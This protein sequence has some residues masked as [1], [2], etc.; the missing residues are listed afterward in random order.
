M[1]LPPFFPTPRCFGLLFPWRIRIRIQRTDPEDPGNWVQAF[2]VSLGQGPNLNL[3][4]G[5]PGPREAAGPMASV[6]SY[7]QPQ[8]TLF[9]RILFLYN[10][11]NLVKLFVVRFE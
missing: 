2:F 4:G 10:F 8:V 9:I 6:G 3:S 5:G 7:F 11:A 1:Y